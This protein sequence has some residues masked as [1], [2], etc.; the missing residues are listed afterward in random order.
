[1][2]FFGARYRLCRTVFFGVLPA[3]PVAMQSTSLTDILRFLEN[4]VFSFWAEIIN[5]LAYCFGT[6]LSQLGHFRS[7]KF[8]SV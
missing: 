8:L 3:F 1:M 6:N 7:P 4:Q 5:Y 2:K